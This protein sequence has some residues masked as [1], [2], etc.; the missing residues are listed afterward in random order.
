MAAT[1]MKT[2]PVDEDREYIA[3]ECVCDVCH[4]KFTKLERA[5]EKASKR[6]WRRPHLHPTTK[7]RMKTRNAGPAR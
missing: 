5:I 7:R 1:T 4:G 2:K 6:K 3:H